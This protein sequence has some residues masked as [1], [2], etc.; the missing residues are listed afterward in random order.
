MNPWLGMG[1]VLAL[2]GGLTAGLRLWQRR[3]GPHPELVRK[4]LHVGMGLV[5]LTFPWVFDTAWPVLVL[6]GMS[7]AALLALRLTPVGRV[8]SDVERPSFGEVYFP[9]AVAVLFTLYVHNAR[10]HADHRL[11]LYL[12]P[13]LLLT[14]ADAAAALVGVGYGR[15]R[16]ATADGQK[17][18]EGSAAFCTCAFFC[19]HV[20]VLLL[21]QTGRPETLLVALL[22]A[23]LAT[24]FEAIAWRGLDNLALPLVSYLLL[25]AYLD[26]DIDR[27]LIRVGVTA[28]MVAFLVVY[29][30]RTTLVG[31]AVLGAYLVGYICWAVGGWRWLLAPLGLYLTYS[32]LSPKE[33]RN[34]QQT[35]TVHAVAAV[36]AA[37]LG[38]L[39]AFQTLGRP[40]VLLLTY[41]IAF[42]GHLAIAGI[43]RLKCDYPQI[44]DARVVPTSIGIAWLIEF[45]LYL[46]AMG[47][48]RATVIAAAF[49][50]AGTAV[51]AVVF[52]FTQ[53][54]LNDCPTDTPRW[55]RQATAGFVGSLV[56]ILPIA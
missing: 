50:L 56:G 29:R 9:V 16:Y 37:G 44:A 51:V 1:S 12:V 55:L 22:M 32:R 49:G 33:A 6:A 23:W 31:S 30:R 7:V 20:P 52:Y 5:T 53:P 17:S 38:W 42:A 3:A 47:V 24:M 4:F 10:E 54:G 2:F 18:A 41:T 43:A 26:M 19:V 34:P 8:L 28:V 13:V 36:A 15:H 27:L 39:F 35:H 40:E 11:V 25:A 48:S 14:L 21:T 45:G 46:I